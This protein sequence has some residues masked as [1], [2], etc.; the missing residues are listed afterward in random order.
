MVILKKF[1][2]VSALFPLGLINKLII[3]QHRAKG[4]YIRPVPC[5]YNSKGNLK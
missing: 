2:V 3:H 1:V 5:S 4:L